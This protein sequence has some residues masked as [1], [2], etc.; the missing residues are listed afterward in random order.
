[1]QQLPAG[2][3]RGADKVVR[4]TVPPSLLSKCKKTWQTAAAL[5]LVSGDC[6]IEV[7]VKNDCIFIQR[8]RD[9]HDDRKRRHE[10]SEPV[11]A[12]A[13]Q[14]IVDA[15]QGD[16]LS[17]AKLAGRSVVTPQL[18]AYPLASR[19]LCESGEPPPK[20]RR[21]DESP[22]DELALDNLERPKPSTSIDSWRFDQQLTPTMPNTFMAMPDTATAESDL[23]SQTILRDDSWQAPANGFGPFGRRRDEVALEG[24]CV[25]AAL[26]RVPLEE[27]TDV[28]DVASA[29]AAMRREL[30][31]CLDLRAED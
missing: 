2:C 31:D 14:A 21:S 9:R 27:E 16:T 19:P 1:M 7:A 6:R 20:L 4:G 30:D 22:L 23:H 5:D 10:Q 17:G 29:A 18:G 28:Y 8:G 11:A 24:A 3:R 12:V 26:R 13:T 15:G 25:A